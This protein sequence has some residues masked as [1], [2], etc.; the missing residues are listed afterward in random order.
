MALREVVLFVGAILVTAVAARAEV[1]WYPVPF[2]L[3]TLAVTMSG[4]VL[5]GRRA[6]VAQSGYL[7]AGAIGL[8]VLAGGA[9]GAEHLTGLTAGYLWSFPIVAGGL[10]FLAARPSWRTPA[11]LTLA[12]AAAHAVNL[13]MGGLWLNALKP[14]IGWSA[15]VA[16]FLLGGLFKSLLA[17]AIVPELD[18]RVKL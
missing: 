5:G 3:Q 11:A 17:A 10:G 18:R 15:G 12:L 9:G 6:F 14:G 1:P 13:T 16:P 8:P 7:G 4:L 2:T